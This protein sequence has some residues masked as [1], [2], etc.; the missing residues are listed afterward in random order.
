ML[1]HN[2]E[3]HSPGIIYRPAKFER[4]HPMVWEL[5]QKQ[6]MDPADSPLPYANKRPSRTN[7]NR[8]HRYMYN[9]RIT[10]TKGT[11]CQLKF[12]WLYPGAECRQRLGMQSGEIKDEWITASSSYADIVGPTDAR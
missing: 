8:G 2:I 3:K 10:R 7:Q 6:S 9:V 11:K 5:L 1:S 4:V 12:F